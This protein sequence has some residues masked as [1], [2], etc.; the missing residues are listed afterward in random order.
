MKYYKI[1]SS[2]GEIRFSLE[3]IK[4]I[5]ENK[6]NANKLVSKEILQIRYQIT[7]KKIL[8]AIMTQ[9]EKS[10]MKER[11]NTY[12][13][14]GM[15]PSLIDIGAEYI[16]ELELNENDEIINIVLIGDLCKCIFEETLIFRGNDFRSECKSILI[17]DSQDIQEELEIFLKECNDKYMDLLKK[18]RYID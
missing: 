13:K 9:D 2:L 3:Q 4:F 7:D 14:L 17:R 10:V 11:I 1:K 12:K 15:Q 5:L 18:H 16:V 6:F 8:D